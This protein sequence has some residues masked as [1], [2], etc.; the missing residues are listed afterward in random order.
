MYYTFLGSG[1]KLLSS[2]LLEGCGKFICLINRTYFSTMFHD[3]LEM[4]AQRKSWTLKLLM[5]SDN[6]FK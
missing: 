3:D 2:I 1:R 5:R 4:C 6:H